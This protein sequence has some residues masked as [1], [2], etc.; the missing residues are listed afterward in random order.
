MHATIKIGVQPGTRFLRLER[1]EQEQD[2]MGIYSVGHWLVWINANHDFSLG[3]FL[4]LWDDGGIERVT[5]REDEGDDVQ[6]I[7]PGD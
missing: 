7:K 1:S 3:T 2:S 5:L 4:R 6:L